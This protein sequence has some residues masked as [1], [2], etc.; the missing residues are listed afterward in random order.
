MASPGDGA[1]RT[2]DAR[3]VVRARLVE[4]V[5]ACALVVAVLGGISSTAGARAPAVPTV[6]LNV[7]V[8][9]GVG[10]LTVSWDPPS[11]SAGATLHYAVRTEPRGRTCATTALSC[12]FDHI[13]DATPWRFTVT[14]ANGAG[15]GP[16]SPLTFA[17]RHLTVVVVAGQSNAI[18]LESYAINPQHHNVLTTGAVAAAAR[19]TLIDWVESGVPSSGLAPVP[20][21]TPQVF[22][23]S[24]IFGPEMGIASTLY[25]D[26]RRDLLVV[27]V[28]F[29]G[30][31]LAT[32]WTASGPLYKSLITETRAALS[33]AADDW[34]SATV[35][36]VYW[37]QGETDAEHA[38]MAASY[39]RHLT[40][41]IHEVRANLS[42]SPRTPF[43][44]GGIDVARYVAYKAQHHQ[45]SA[46]A[47]RLELAGNAT[48]R[49]AE[50]QIA[51]TVAFCYL[52]DTSTLARHPTQY[53]HL[54]D[55]AELRLGAE[56][57][58]A[59]AHQLT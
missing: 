41:L 28:A 25:Q 36:A 3:R 27:K 5:A 43:V 33:W 2:A 34:W 29:A 59:S 52:V 26:N 16:G 31:S 44:L 47:C 14:A 55:V 23:G 10:W 20:L 35:A 38:G 17:F 24:P 40:A 39:A 50:Q 51:R 6:P 48:V 18:G 11:N 13:D 32:D 7:S 37:V 58:S 49:A 30:T 53:L 42:L 45:C 57:A 21:T 12:R 1:V 54:T 22:T 56:L 19:H 9:P 46:A 4:L 8:T 15:Q